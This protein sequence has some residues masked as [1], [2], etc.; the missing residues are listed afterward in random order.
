MAPRTILAQLAVVLRDDASKG[1]K[2][3]SGDVKGLERSAVDFT[4]TMQGAKWGSAFTRDLG[5]CNRTQIGEMARGTRNLTG[6]TAKG[7]ELLPDIVQARVAL[8]SAY[9]DDGAGRLDMVMK[10]ADIAGQQD[11]PERFRRSLPRI[12]RACIPG[13]GK[14]ISGSDYFSFYRRAKDERRRASDE[15]LAR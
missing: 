13:R 1:A 7:L 6:S 12:L 9:G 8:Q 14:Q 10:A 15:L 5:F 4:K 2:A 11:D 3:L